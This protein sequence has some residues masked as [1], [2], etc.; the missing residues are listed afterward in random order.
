MVKGWGRRDRRMIY[1]I[2]KDK[3]VYVLNLG[4]AEVVDPYHWTGIVV[5]KDGKFY[6]VRQDRITIAQQ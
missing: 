6:T 3:Q 1:N 2:V 4:W 5:R